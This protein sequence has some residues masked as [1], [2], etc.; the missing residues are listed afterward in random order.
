MQASVVFSHNALMSIYGVHGNI[1]GNARTMQSHMVEAMGNPY[2]VV[3]L[4]ID[5]GPNI[6][7][8]V[9]RVM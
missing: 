8:D 9:C 7:L 1:P 5:A 6:P 3:F 2:A 4:H